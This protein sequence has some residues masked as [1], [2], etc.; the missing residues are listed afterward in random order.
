MN[1]NGNGV[2]KGWHRFAARGTAYY[3][4]GSNLTIKKHGTE[5]RVRQIGDSRVIATG[6]T[7]AEATTNML[8]TID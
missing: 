3:W 1:T 8:A 6:S 4:K 7:M 5:W 2:P